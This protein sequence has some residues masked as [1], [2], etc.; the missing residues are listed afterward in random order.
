MR[1]AGRGRGAGLRWRG[2]AAGRRAVGVFLVGGAGGQRFAQCFGGQSG[3]GQQS[4]DAVVQVAAEP[5]RS[6]AT[7]SRARRRVDWIGVGVVA[8][9]Q[10][11]GL[12]GES[13]E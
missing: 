11:G 3:S 2:S 9:D 5:A 7:F 6:S 13:V 8:R 10:A 4:G 1:V 12:V